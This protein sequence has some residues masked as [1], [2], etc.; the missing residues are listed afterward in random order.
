MPYCYLNLALR[1]F[2][3]FFVSFLFFYFYYCTRGPSFNKRSSIHA[4]RRHS[5]TQLANNC[6][7]FFLF[8][9]FF[10]FGYVQSEWYVFLPGGVFLPCDHRLDFDIRLCENSIK[11]DQ[12]ICTPTRICNSE[13][14]QIQ[15]NSNR[16]NIRLSLREFHPSSTN[17]VYSPS[18]S[19]F[20]CMSVRVYFR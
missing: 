11:F 15:A 8:F 2:P 13:R 6:L 3:L 4:S 20:W 9:L 10:F 12:I 19:C 18:E 1:F 17:L 14:I 7:S 5:Y 16:R